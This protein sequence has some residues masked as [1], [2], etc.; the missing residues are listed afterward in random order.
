MKFSEH[1][2]LLRPAKPRGIFPALAWAWPTGERDLLLRAAIHSDLTVAAAAYRQWESTYDFD[3]VDFAKMRLLVSISNR[4]PPDILA[5]KDQPRLRGIER[6]L[7]SECI[8]ALRSAAPALAALETAGIPVMVF[9]GAVRTVLDI[10]NLRG[11]YAS[12]LDLLV[13][14]ND[15]VRA[16]DAICA[17]GWAYVMGYRP[18]FDWLIGANLSKKGAGELDLH[19]YAY[20]QLVL[21]D[22]KPDALWGRAIETR[23]LGHRVFVPSP[24]DRLLMAI[25]HG[26]IGGHEQSDWMVDCAQLVRSGEID[27]PLF[28]RLARERGVDALAATTLSYLAGPLEV[29]VP[30]AAL[31]QLK[32]GTLLH[33]FRRMSALLQARPKREHSVPS[34]IARGVARAIRMANKSRMI[35]KVEKLRREAGGE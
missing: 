10:S 22:L 29:P 15:F 25:A 19:K 26:G 17:A 3:A 24:T 1:V 20:H 5:A 7:W 32:A 9:K 2:A 11:R 27:W 31:S 8:M 6:K 14:P 12:E 34:A 16:W 13:R 35:L 30:E 33:P 4:I 28:V 21:S 18:R 23:F